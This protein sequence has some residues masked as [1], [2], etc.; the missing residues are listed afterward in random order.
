MD[1]IPFLHQIRARLKSSYSILSDILPSHVVTAL[2]DNS[3]AEQH[4][5]NDIDSEGLERQWLMLQ[6]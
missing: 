5:C 3:S 6:V 4:C 1:R 2:L